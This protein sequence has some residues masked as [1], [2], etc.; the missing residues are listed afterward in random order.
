MTAIYA[1]LGFEKKI[2][3]SNLDR[4]FKAIKDDIAEKQKDYD[5]LPF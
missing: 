1:L 5:E 3:T 4:L 2:G